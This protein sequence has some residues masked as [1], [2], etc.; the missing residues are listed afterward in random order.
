MYWSRPS[1]AAFQVITSGRFWVITKVPPFLILSPRFGSGILQLPLADN[2]VTI[3]SV[4]AVL[5]AVD[6]RIRQI[7]VALPGGCT[8]Q[9]SRSVIQA[10]TK[11]RVPT[12]T[13]C[14]ALSRIGAS[15]RFLALISGGLPRAVEDHLHA[16]RLGLLLYY[17]V[18]GGRF[19]PTIAVHVPHS[20]FPRRRR[21][22]W[23]RIK[24]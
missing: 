18:I 17:Y 2:L 24:T 11:P 3:A 8:S 1:L 5:E 21:T 20:A 19:D 12:K 7:T 23:L 16:D 6:L 22:A 14:V 15:D 9:R 10:N 13:L 4:T